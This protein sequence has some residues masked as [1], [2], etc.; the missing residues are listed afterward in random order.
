MYA[1]QLALEWA[2]ANPGAADGYLGP[3][4]DDAIHRAQS[5]LGLVVDGLAGGA[6]QAGL[7]REIIHA[8]RKQHSLPSGLTRGQVEHESGFRLGNYSPARDD[9]SFDAGVTQRNSAHHSL[10]SAFDPVT[11]IYLLAKNTK[12]AY[13]RYV[14]VE[15]EHRRW[16]LAA[17]NWNAP[18]YA[19]YYAGVQPWAVP[20][21]T[22]AAAF[23]AYL[24]SATAYLK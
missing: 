18:A 20:G 16:S 11:S 19:N 6:T 10:E 22:A 15:D 24:E 2:D 9:G 5:A 7:A 8:A 23:A 21:P 12:A 14:D 1:L 3:N 17:G 13:D 4:T